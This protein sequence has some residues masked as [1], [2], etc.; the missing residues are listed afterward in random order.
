MTESIVCPPERS[1]PAQFLALLMKGF[2]SFCAQK[3]TDVN[4]F[5]NYKE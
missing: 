2:G 4:K 1:N 5:F 3:L